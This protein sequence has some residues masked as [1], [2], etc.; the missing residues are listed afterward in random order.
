MT[1]SPGGRSRAGL[2]REIGLRYPPAWSPS[3]KALSV[4]RLRS[5]A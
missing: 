4:M 2:G 5:S 3:L 1:L